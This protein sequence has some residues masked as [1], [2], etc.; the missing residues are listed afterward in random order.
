MNRI[1]AIKALGF[2]CTSNEP[3]EVGP[4]GNS[5]QPTLG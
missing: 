1:K 4:T 5:Y 3:Y 2:R